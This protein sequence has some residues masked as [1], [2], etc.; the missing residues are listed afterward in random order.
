MKIRLKNIKFGIFKKFKD[1]FDI[2]KCLRTNFFF[3]E[4]QVINGEFLNI[5]L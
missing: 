4:V 2:I 5:K 3:L 1:Q